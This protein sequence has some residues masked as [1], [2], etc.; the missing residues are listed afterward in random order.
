MVNKLFFKSLL[1]LDKKKI[2]LFLSQ[3]VSALIGIC[4]GKLIA[5]NFLPE[6]FGKYN[7]ILATF[8]FFFSLF[9]NPF[10]Q[11]LKTITNS[12]AL[13]EK[14]DI[15]FKFA[16]VLNLISSFLICILL[17]LT[18]QLNFYIILLVALTFPANFV[19][20]L[21]LDFFNVKGAINLFTKLSVTFSVINLLAVVIV[22]FLF[23]NKFDSLILLW[24]IQLIAFFI[25]S[26]F[27][28]KK[29]AFYNNTQQRIIDRFYVKEYFVYAW[30]LIVLAF[31]NWINS[32]FDRYLIEYFLTIKEVGIY[33][34][35]FSLGSKF[36]LMIN[37][38]F[39]ALLTPI[40]FN[41]EYTVELKKNQIKKYAGAYIFIGI[42]I[43]FCLF[44]LYEYI[45]K[46][47]LSSSYSDGF[48][49]I[50]WSAFAYFLITF[51]YLFELLFY[52]YKRT[53]VILIANLIAAIFNI[54]LNIIF[55]P[56]LG[57]S[58]VV[59]SLI[60]SSFVRF[61][62]VWIKYKKIN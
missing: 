21:L 7:L 43:L 46:I 4:I 50:F 14:F 19:Y 15:H 9:L 38:F 34:A 2:T 8:S 10:L 42:I 45:G 39:L 41:N 55:I 44:F 27:F 62:I 29:Y 56:R 35:N 37:P 32:Y 20:N 5:V 22:I 47:L 11:Y 26:L 30:P 51:A 12:E 57:L 18:S 25:S 52:F 59:I 61:L 53:K 36:F 17:F 49:V 1:P 23:K 28:I 58:A 48:Y 24:S 13:K 31:W 6:E 60:S 40:A 16:V 3:V 33:N 54:I